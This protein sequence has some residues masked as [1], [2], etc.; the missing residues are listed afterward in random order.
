VAVEI[1]LADYR[2]LGA[3]RI[4]SA[5]SVQCCWLRQLVH[6]LDSG[7]SPKVQALMRVNRGDIFYDSHTADRVVRM[8]FG[9]MILAEEFLSHTAIR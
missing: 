5:G 8:S 7:L 3:W 4:C 6:S 1:L 2:L 9:A